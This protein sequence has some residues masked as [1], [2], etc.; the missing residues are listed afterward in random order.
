LA[1]KQ[2]GQQLQLSLEV[3][4]GMLTGSISTIVWTSI[5]VLNNAIT[6]RLV[7]FVLAFVAIVLVSLE[8]K[9]ETKLYEVKS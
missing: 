4:A 8:S 7:S 3:L 5:P 6:V 1:E 2:V 9:K